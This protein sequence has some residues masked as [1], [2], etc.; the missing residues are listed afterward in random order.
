[1]SGRRHKAATFAEV[2]AYI[3]HVLQHLERRHEVGAS[4]G[5]GDRLTRHETHLRFPVDVAPDVLGPQRF[6]QGAVGSFAGPDIDHVPAGAQH[7][8]SGQHAVQG[9]AERDEDVPIAVPPARLRAAHAVVHASLRVHNATNC[10]RLVAQ[11]SG[12]R[13]QAAGCT[14]ARKP[15]P[16][17]ASAG[18]HSQRA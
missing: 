9:A 17:S 5:E 1:M 8:G 4:V 7:L 2:P 15:N 18:N 10:R 13:W 16:A 3:P 11:P 6:E 12:P 14:S